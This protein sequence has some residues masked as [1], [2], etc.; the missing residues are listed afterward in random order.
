MKKKISFQMVAH[1][2]QIYGL[3]SV[4]WG[5]IMMVGMELPGTK[6]MLNSWLV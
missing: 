1:G 2:F 5:T 6:E 3:V 4:V